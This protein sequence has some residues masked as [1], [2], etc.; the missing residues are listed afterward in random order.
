[1]FYVMK[2]LRPRTT[3]NVLYTVITKRKGIVIGSQSSRRETLMR[4]STF[5]ISWC[6]ILL[7]SIPPIGYA[8]EPGLSGRFVGIY[9][10]VTLP[11]DLQHVHGTGSLSSITATDIDLKVSP[12]YGVKL[13]L[14]PQHYPSHLRLETEFFYTNPHMRQQD[15]TF[16]APGAAAT[17]NFTGAHLRV[18][19]WAVNLVFRHPGER[20]EPYAGVGLGIFWARVAGASAAGGIGTSADTSPGLNALAGMRF[21]LTERLV[22][23]TEYKY[24]RAS[25]DFGKDIALHTL[26]EAHHFVGGLAL[27]F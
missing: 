22:F 4:R 24:T 11:Q 6:T 9:G 16:T 19:T 17:V 18:A 27:Q 5:F 1:M 3:E 7:V 20:F 2:K 21:L 23:F 13:G 26:Y 14:L 12:I 15:V 10:G 8:D 25:F